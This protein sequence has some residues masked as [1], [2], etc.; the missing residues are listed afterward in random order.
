MEASDCDAQPSQDSGASTSRKCFSELETKGSEKS[1]KDSASSPTAAGAK[2]SLRFPPKGSD[3]TLPCENQ[4]NG[5]SLHLLFRHHVAVV[6]CASLFGELLPY[7][8]I[9]RDCVGTYRLPTTLP[10]PSRH[11]LV[12]ELLLLR[13]DPDRLLARNSFQWA[14]AHGSLLCQ[15]DHQAYPAKAGGNAE[16]FQS[17]RLSRVDDMEGSLALQSS[18]G[19]RADVFASSREDRN[20]AT[21]LN[22]ATGTCSSAGR[23]STLWQLPLPLLDP[24]VLLC[25][26]G[27]ELVAQKSAVLRIL[28]MLRSLAPSWAAR[29]DNFGFHFKSA[30]SAASLD[31]QE[32][33]SYRV[34]FQCLS[35]FDAREWS[36]EQ[37]MEVLSDLDCIRLAHRRRWS[38]RSSV[39]RIQRAVEQPEGESAASTWQAA[40]GSGSRSRWE[41]SGVE[42][43]AQSCQPRQVVREIL[44]GQHATNVAATA[45]SPIATSSAFGLVQPVSA[46]KEQHNSVQP[47]ASQHLPPNS[48]GGRGA[49]RG[50]AVAS[51]RQGLPEAASFA[52][53]DG[54]SAIIVMNRLMACVE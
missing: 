36:R 33:Q 15:G 6:S 22:D 18:S 41:I 49:S 28:R 34:V 48:S 37:L 50:S 47:V 54:T 31:S 43:G 16:A 40:E 21:A 9:F 11:L 26:S 23:N 25:A 12:Q 45:G 30:I 13:Q 20:A 32:L 44:T 27:T 29:D 3:A 24:S 53:S 14:E 38:L 19:M 51:T 8:H 35:P 1:E 7:S 39:A 2:N 17:D 52:E 10:S 42:A 46:S 4:E 5:D